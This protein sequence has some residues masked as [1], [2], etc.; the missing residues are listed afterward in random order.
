MAKV[1]KKKPELSA[2]QVAAAKTLRALRLE[3]GASQRDFATMIGIDW[4]R[5]MRREGGLA[6]WKESELKRIRYKFQLW[7]TGLRRKFHDALSAIEHSE[8]AD[9]GAIPLGPARACLSVP[10]ASQPLSPQTAA[11][12]T[13]SQ[14]TGGD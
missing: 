2:R 6:P 5:V 1:M 7:A 3:L 12:L 9:A 11:G 13:Q 10:V 4:E 8:E 14:Q